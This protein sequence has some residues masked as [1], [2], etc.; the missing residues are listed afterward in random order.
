MR[1]AFSTLF[2]LQTLLAAYQ[3][4]IA[5]ISSFSKI[6]KKDV[7]HKNFNR[8]KKIK[9]ITRMYNQIYNTSKEFLKSLKAEVFFSCKK[10]EWQAR[11]SKA[12]YA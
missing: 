6:Y 9:G 7:I 3:E 1:Q 12:A 11:Y 10:L 4:Y 2:Y 8:H 5:Q